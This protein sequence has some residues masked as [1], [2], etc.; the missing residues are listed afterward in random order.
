MQIPGTIPVFQEIT[1]LNGVILET[2]IILICNPE[3]TNVL[4]LCF[5]FRQSSV[6][7]V[8]IFQ[9]LMTGVHNNLKAC[10]L[11]I[12]N[13]RIPPAFHGKMTPDFC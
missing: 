2:F 13:L 10:H 1:V 5:L 11:E 3:R 8:V 6:F 4:C 12:V 7:W 9:K